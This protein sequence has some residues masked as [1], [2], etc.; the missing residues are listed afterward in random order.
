M[1][2]ADKKPDGS[3]GAAA[4]EGAETTRAYR[5]N[6]PLPPSLGAALDLFRQARAAG[7]TAT[8]VLTRTES[9]KITAKRQHDVKAALRT[10]S[11]ATK[12]IESGYRFDDEMAKAKIEAMGKAVAL[13][14]RESALL[15]RVLFTET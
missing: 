9:A 15:L 12:A 6:D 1:T 10:L 8:I 14:D 13:L 11:F 7:L 2:G 4:D 3:G 5:P